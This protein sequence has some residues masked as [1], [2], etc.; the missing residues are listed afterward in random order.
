[1]TISCQ[2]E[3]NQ[4]IVVFYLSKKYFFVIVWY[5]ISHT[6][7]VFWDDPASILGIH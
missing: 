2:I 6:H 1:L 7:T 5:H 3:S 4:L